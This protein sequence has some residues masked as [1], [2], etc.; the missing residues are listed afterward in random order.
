MRAEPTEEQMEAEQTMM[1]EESDEE[2][3]TQ[4]KTTRARVTPKRA[5]K[6]RSKTKD[7]KR[8]STEKE[9]NTEEDE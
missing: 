9:E 3:E 7:I 6:A 1:M 4:K 2:E 8:A 5:S